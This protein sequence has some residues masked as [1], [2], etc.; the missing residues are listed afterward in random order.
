MQITELISK[1]C[2]KLDLRARTKGEAFEELIAL[3]VADGRVKNKKAALTAIKER[4]KL[5]STGIGT[6]VAIPH[7]KCTVVD[8]LVAAFGKTDRGI[9]Y[10]SLDDEP[11]HLIFLLLTPENDTGSHVKALAR[12]SRLLKQQHFRNSL[13]E[14][15]SVTKV[16]KIIRE[17]EQRG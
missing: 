15:T 8:E 13:M 10:Q 6:G 16:M 7:A 14:A 3:L 5:M 11:V 1:D 12:I 4:E 9:N 2:V 17:A